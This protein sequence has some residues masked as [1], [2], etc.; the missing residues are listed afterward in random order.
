MVSIK[1]DVLVDVLSPKEFDLQKQIIS[2]V[3]GDL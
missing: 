3:F 1:G 2:L